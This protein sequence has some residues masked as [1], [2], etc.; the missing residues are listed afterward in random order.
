M[1][2]YFLLYKYSYLAI[3]E[4]DK[5][6][7][8]GGPE[9]CHFDEKWIKGLINFCL[10][11]NLELNFISFHDF[12]DIG[13]LPKQ[14]KLVWKWISKYAKKLKFNGEINVGE[15]GFRTDEFEVALK[16][17]DYA[18][19]AGVNFYCKDFFY[20]AWEKGSLLEKDF[21]PK[22]IYFDLLEYLKSEK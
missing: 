18:K 6:A 8:I 2:E 17:I 20:N 19:K 3:R 10:K 15:W 21:K 4:V 1:E 7:L 16:R 5:N 12:D 11:E 14:T 9:I 13:E 22:P